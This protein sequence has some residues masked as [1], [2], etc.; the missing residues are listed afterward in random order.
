MIQDQAFSKKK[1]FLTIILTF[2]VLTSFRVGW[3]YYHK[4]PEQ[5][6]AKN[7][8]IDLSDWEFKDNETIVLDGEWEFFPQ[9][10]TN[11]HAP[12]QRMAKIINVPEESMMPDHSTIKTYGYGTYKL[13]ILLPENV[14]SLYGIRF[15]RV[16]TSA[17]IF[18][19]NV[20]ITDFNSV[21]KDP[22]NKVI[23]RGPFSA[24]FHPNSSE[25]ELVVHVSNYEIPFFSGITKSVQFGT[26]TAIQKQSRSST[27]LQIV[28]GL[29]YIL[30]SMYA[31]I[32]YYIGRGKYEKELFYFGFMLAIH[33]F[34]I[35]IDD[36]VVL[37]LPIHIVTTNKLLLFLFLSTLFTLLIF[38]KHLFHIH[39][40]F[41]KFLTYMYFFLVIAQLIVPFQYYPYLLIPVMIFYLL[42]IA[43]LF[44]QTVKTIRGGHQDA[45]FILIFVTS[46]T[47]N[48]IWGFMINY[49]L[50]EIPYYPFDFIF[51]IVVI[52]L[53]LFKHH[54]RL[55]RLNEQQTKELQE[56]DKKKDEFL[57]NTSHEL[58][59]PLHGII[60]I[61]RTIL[62]D[63]E[64]RLSSVNKENLTLLVQIGERM[65]FTLN[66]ILDI[67][68]LKDKDIRLNKESV[69]LS[70]IIS[71][72]LDMIQFMTE[73][74]AIKIHHNVPVTFPNVFADENRLIQIVFN[75][76]HNAVKYT[77]EGTVTIRAEAQDGVAIIY[78]E[79]TGIGI[80]EETKKKIFMPYE[81]E[82]ASITAIGG[83]IGLGLHI[84]KRL[85]E[86]H[87]G[88]ISVESDINKGTVFFFSI[89]LANNLTKEPK[90]RLKAFDTVVPIHPVKQEKP[91]RSVEDSQPTS[92]SR[93]SNS[94]FSKVAQILIV[95][96]D[97]I[98]LKVIRSLLEGEYCI[99]TALN[100]EMALEHID[101]K[102]FDLIISDVMM[103]KL[104]GYELTKIIRKKFSIAELP[105]LLIT[106]RS[107]QEDL[108]AGF[109]A[110]AN[111]YVTKPVEAM[112]LKARVR[113]LTQLKQ[114]IDEQLRTE[115][116]W[117]QAQI[118]PHF[119]MNT[120]N[121]IASLGE[122][123]NSRM[124]KLLDEF[125][126]YLNKSFAVNN[127][128]SLV[129]L[130]EELAL[131]RSYLY[132]EQ[133][134]FGNR[135]YVDWNVDE[136]LTFRIPPLSIQPIVE[137][138]VRHGILKK[139]HG[140]TVT[141]SVKENEIDYEVSIRDNGVGMAKD[142]INELLH[143]NIYD[144]KGI[145]I[146][147]TNRRLIQ[148]YGKG[149][150]ISSVPQQG[151]TMSFLIP[152]N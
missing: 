17:D 30:H 23:E 71:G 100:G 40:R 105:I 128:K 109:L 127:T 72:V 114:S 121:T 132:I 25:V 20:P 91:I 6:Y 79:D 61:A 89:P 92:S 115:A 110:G 4:T 81:Q 51:S 151:T 39:S 28:V 106:A 123:D 15:K 101:K 99:Q 116:A 78:V 83:G 41:F 27:T 139:L 136:T 137:N 113:A 94:R 69:N 46:Y 130:K 68:R 131:T 70:T 150:Q 135:I 37:Q 86:L 5:P 125:G 3:V 53:L 126:N 111:D 88:T 74:K 85:V 149:L 7:G 60:N 82:D 107:Q 67:T 48:M 54:I 8:V 18:I 147:N 138:A 63:K 117:L 133:E 13:K 9:T 58:R 66:D 56:A 104:S 142:K 77:N 21:T 73:K 57:A 19:N 12:S 59:N 103:P 2:L 112:E 1:I 42:S 36:D 10:L 29:I 97:P 146:T 35:L 47:S 108:N 119:L 118:Q 34:S 50:V 98:N 84:C 129:L 65:T 33:A 38:I 120:L 22:G 140:G 11:N 122:I 145:G 32:V 87:G 49:Q 26:E 43:F 14:H 75:L 144:K 80:S 90:S 134:R 24:T 64:A 124:V 45:I 44:I 55:N 102:N 52:A 62:N 93:N 76:I 95:D 141:I 31:L 16:T 148:M 96:D 152:K 143:G